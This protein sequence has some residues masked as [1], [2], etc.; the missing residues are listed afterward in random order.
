[1]FGNVYRD[2]KIL[3]TGH[4]GFKGS[5]LTKWLEILG[6]DV[7]GLSLPNDQSLSHYSLLDLDCRE[8]FT[9]I[10]DQEALN[11]VIQKLQPD[12]IFHLAA[13][14]LVIPSYEDP[15]ETWGT[16]VMGTAHI[17][18]AMR[19]T[20]SIQ[21]GVMITT[22]KCYK[23]KE[24]ATG[25]SE[26]DELGGHDPYSASKAAC[27][28]VIGS[29]RSSFWEKGASPLIASAR[30]GNV[31]GGGDWSDY[32]IIPDI[33]RALQAGE[34]ITL[35]NP[36]SVRPWQHVLESLS[37]Y[38]MLGQ[39]LLAGETQF[40]TAYNF[41]PQSNDAIPV[42]DIVQKFQAEFTD[43]KYEIIGSDVEKR[44]ETNLLK[45]NSSKAVKELKWLPVWDTVEGIHKTIEW[46]S[47]YISGGN[48]ITARQIE[49]Y[50]N[51]AVVKKLNWTQA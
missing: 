41:G 48:V 23:N 16:N 43:L 1:M 33:V 27:E 30:A 25:Y 7:C 3:V 50:C 17:L 40:A 31:I 6:A 28:L 20:D 18:E 19:H 14:S 46:Y 36:Q 13:Q 21:G 12:F 10:R 5:W 9:D 24:S 44:H 51:H 22:D 15:I 4:T 34:T 29:F 42:I 32:R 26:S 39:K 47:A 8:F 45:L 38:L 11:A 2:K 35:R 37:G 49:D